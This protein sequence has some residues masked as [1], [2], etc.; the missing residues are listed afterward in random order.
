MEIAPP[1]PVGRIG[2]IKGPHRTKHGGGAARLGRRHEFGEPAGGCRLVIVDEG[3]EI[4]LAGIEA[5]IA[6]DRYVARGRMP[7]ADR[8]PQLL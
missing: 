3:K 6:G 4:R 7:V 5:G 1:H 2:T 8:Q